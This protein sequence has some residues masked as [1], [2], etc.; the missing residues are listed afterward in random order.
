MSA[1]APESTMTKEPQYAPILQLAAEHGPEALGMMSGHTWHVDPKRLGFILARYKFVAKMLAG[2][3]RVLEIGCSDGFASR[4]V[5]QH[6]GTLT[7][8]DMD[9]LFIENARE[10][11]ASDK[12]PIE[13]IVHDALASS[14]PC[15]ATQHGKHV[16]HSGVFDA[17]YSLDVLEHI[18]PCDE[19]VFLRNVA[20]S[21]TPAGVFVVG[22]PSLESQLYASEQSR[23]GHVNCKSQDALRKTLA[24]WFENVFVF[25]MNDET[26]H[27]GHHGM[28]HYL[29]AVCAGKKPKQC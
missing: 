28:C 15:V 26:L 11:V 23:V 7:C 19:F 10:N 21:L 16:V 5:R 24:Q 9:P 2:K 22:M 1:P 12:W 13:F 18:R 17:I 29:L 6:V 14:A 20:M 25:G 8:V 3:E 27:T 4:V